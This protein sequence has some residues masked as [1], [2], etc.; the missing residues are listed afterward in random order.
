M[1]AGDPREDVLGTRRVLVV[2]DSRE[3]SRPW[4]STADLSPV[5]DIRRHYIWPDEFFEVRYE[6][7]MVSEDGTE[8]VVESTEYEVFEVPGAN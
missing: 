2:S 7:V 3:I 8:T 1:A 6:V 4:T 5:R